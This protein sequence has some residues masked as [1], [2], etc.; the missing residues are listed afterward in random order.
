M[1]NIIVIGAGASGMMAAIHAA[2]EGNKVTVIEEN[3]KPLKKLLVTG[4]GRCNITNMSWDGDV[5]RGSDPEKAMRIINKFDHKKV[6]EFF[7]M[8][9]IV[10]KERNGWVY[11]LNDSAAVVA[12][13]LISVAE[14]KKIKIKT[15][16]KVIGVSKRIDG[17]FSVDVEGWSYKADT[18]IISCGTGAY[19]SEEGYKLAE[20]TANKYNA[21]FENFLP[22]LT[23]LKTNDNSVYKW[24]GV[25][26]EAA[27]KVIYDGEIQHRQ[28]GELQLTESGIS[29]IPVFQIS[30]YVSKALKKGRKVKV[31]IDFLPDYSEEDIKSYLEFIR[32]NYP[33]RTDKQ[34]AAGLIPERLAEHIT[35][36]CFDLD[37]SIETIKNYVFRVSGTGDIRASQICTGGVD[38]DALTDDLMLSKVPGLYFT[39]EAIDVD[40]ACGGY[41][42]QWAW[43]SGKVAAD[44][45][46]KED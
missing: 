8:I 45:A 30:R 43:S 39:G 22:A 17:T 13:T 5:I 1:K 29:G 10:T 27:I 28:R 35:S 19:I 36:G 12:K 18:V 33:Q 23:S 15:N 21:H 46:S 7:N 20:N 6:I 31:I 37:D 25:R 40:G 41:N 9:G 42:L 24:A 3:N 38:L 44:A 4:N 14:S 32:E 2:K 11:P 34:L 16:Q 26:T